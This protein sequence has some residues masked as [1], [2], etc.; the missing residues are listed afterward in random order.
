MSMVKHFFALS[1]ILL[2]DDQ[3]CNSVIAAGRLDLTLTSRVSMTVMSSTYLKC[4]IFVLFLLI[5]ASLIIARKTIGPSLVPCG[6]P[7]W[8]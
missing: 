2:S 4:L 1:R 5:T 7:V 8:T 3:V 6:T